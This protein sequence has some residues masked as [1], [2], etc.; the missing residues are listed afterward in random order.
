MS[1]LFDL[2]GRIALVTGSSRGI[3]NAL[4]VG[5]AQAGAKVIVNS[6]NQDDVNAAVAE[7]RAA[8]YEAGG[9]AFDVTNSQRVEAAIASIETDI[10]PIDICVNNAGIQRRV[11]LHEVSVE[12]WQEVLDTN[13]TS[14]FLVGAA[15]ARRMIPRNSGKIINICSLMSALGRPS[16]GPYTASK[17]GLKMLTQGM[18]ADWARYGMQINAI[19]PGYFLTELTKPL[20]DDPQ[21]DSWVKTRTPAGRWGTTDELIGA[22]V[23]LASK[24]SD[25]INGQIIYVDGGLISV[26]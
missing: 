7:L 3:G 19:G 26:V 14:A 15:V 12:V 23:F 20:A 17:G 2:H 13:L 10:G 9:A 8:G 16:T 1:N 21:F 11:P 22:A 24:A 25:F 18:C 6:R 4:A 5:L